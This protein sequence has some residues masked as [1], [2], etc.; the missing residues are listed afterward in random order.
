MILGTEPAAPSE[1]QNRDED[2]GADNHVQRVHA[3]HREI[4]PVEHLD[5]VNACAFRKMQLVWIGVP[6]LRHHR[7]ERIAG[8]QVSGNKVIIVLRFVLDG[9]DSEKRQTQYQSQN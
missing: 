5:V 4:N 6:M 1:N 3:G 9:L 7:I 8:N 2:A